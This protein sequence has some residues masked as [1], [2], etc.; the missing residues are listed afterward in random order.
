MRSRER[1]VLLG[2]TGSV[3]AFRAVDL[4]SRLT[5]GGYRVDV[6]LTSGALQFVRS[7]SF[8]AVTHR[9]VY[10]DES[11]GVL[12]GRALHVELAERAG[13]VVVAP[14]TADLIGRYACGLA[15]DLLA[16]LLL[17]TAAPI[18]F[19][20]AMNTRMWNH[21]AVRENVALLEKRGARMIGPESGLLSCGTEGLGRLW[22]V[23]LLYA[24][25]EELL[26]AASLSLNSS[27]DEV[28]E[29]TASGR[30]PLSSPREE[31]G[32]KEA[33]EMTEKRK[34]VKKP[35]V[36]KSARNNKKGLAAKKK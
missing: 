4:A 9:S 26:P 36:R 23:D 33:S 18:L 10:T 11:P 6:V 15:P 19:A 30:R 34:P 35:T 28:E 31:G 27:E 29:V 2:V 8:E 5:K 22:P 16:S 20:P 7:L 12:A 1:T 17:A 24:K 13:V 14:A 25:I 21:P 3:A 32:G